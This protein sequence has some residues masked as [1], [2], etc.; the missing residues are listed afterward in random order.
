MEVIPRS[1]IEPCQN[2]WTRQL[3]LMVNAMMSILKRKILLKKG[4]I[5]M[6]IWWYKALYTCLSV[7]SVCVALGL[8]TI[9]LENKN[10]LKK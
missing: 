5:I 2:T 1:L 4:V 3:V 7:L 8:Y 10:I 9:Y 6:P